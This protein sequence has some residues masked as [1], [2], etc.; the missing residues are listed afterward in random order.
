MD[1]I[2]HST[3]SISNINPIRINKKGGGEGSKLNLKQATYWDEI[4]EIAFA[5]LTLL[6]LEKLIYRQ[7]R[8]F[9]FDIS[10]SIRN[11]TSLEMTSDL[12]FYISLRAQAQK[13]NFIYPKSENIYIYIKFCNL[14]NKHVV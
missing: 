13:N 5:A 4:S 9:N 2:Y 10:V 14:G 3:T 6:L 8:Y 12:I 7:S 11:D 1:W